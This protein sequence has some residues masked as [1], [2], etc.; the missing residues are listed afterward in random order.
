MMLVFS[1]YAEVIC[2]RMA[3]ERETVG[4][5]HYLILFFKKCSNYVF[6]QAISL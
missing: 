3:K 1:V 2:A 4:V 6:L 5:K